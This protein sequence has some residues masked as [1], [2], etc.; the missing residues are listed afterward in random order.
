MAKSARSFAMP[1]NVSDAG[2]Y[3]REKEWG[4][5]GMYQIEGWPAGRE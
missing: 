3:A 1:P 4:P 2:S 5:K